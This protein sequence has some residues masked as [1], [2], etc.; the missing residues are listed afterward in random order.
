MREGR[1]RPIKPVDGE[2]DEGPDPVDRLRQ[3]STWSVAILAVV[4]L[5]AALYFAREPVVPVVT[6]FVVGVMLS[7]A[8]R[9]LEEQKVPR[10]LSAALM[11]LFT[12]VVIGVVVT[13]IASPMGDL[14]GRIPEIG[15]KLQVFQDAW[16]RLELSLGVSPATAPPV[17][18]LPKL[19]WVPT[20]LSYLTPPVT[21]LMYFL[22]VLLLFN[23]WWPDLRRQ[24]LMTFA[25]HES[26]LTVLKILN[27]IEASL[28]AYLLTVTSINLGVGAVGGAIVW[29]TGL[30]FPF[31]LGA[32]GDAQLH[33]DR[34]ADPDDHRAGVGRNRLGADPRSRAPA[35]GPVHAG[36]SS[37]RPVHHPDHHRTA[38]RDQQPGRHPV[39]SLLDLDVGADRGVPRLAAA[40][41]R[42]DPEGTFA[43]ERL[44]VNGNSRCGM[45]VANREFAET[46]MNDAPEN[47]AQSAVEDDA[48]ARL[49][50]DLTA[51][52]NDI[53][54]LTQQIADAVNALAAVAQNQGRRSLRQARANIDQA[55][56]GASDRAGAV[57]IAAQD[58]ASSVADSLAEAIQER[59]ITSV[60]LAMSVGFVI[61][62]A[63][64]R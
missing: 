40:N 58:A 15:G 6:A 49:K 36:S 41:R 13:L 33:P 55:V 14:A 35:G 16:R 1:V 48:T 26:R 31:G 51:V 17:I 42:T 11:A 28:A 5:G 37:R 46:K 32:G 57:T 47:A 56:S 8:A 4:G 23:S 27:E 52:K 39:A 25:S 30:P 18:P 10:L 44:G 3:I 38:T 50:K 19:E 9:A 22:V 7:P 64:R 2:E 20:T 24:L 61:G 62:V 54:H 63:W 60:A 45:R 29:L 21:G 53:A 12:A 43:T 34:R 59:P